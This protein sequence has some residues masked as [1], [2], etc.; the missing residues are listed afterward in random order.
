MNVI[1]G[2]TATLRFLISRRS[3]R[4]QRRVGTTREQWRT[5]L[6][7]QAVAKVL[8]VGPWSL[9]ICAIPANRPSGAAAEPS[10]TAKSGRQDE[11]EEEARHY[12]SFRPTQPG[13]RTTCLGFAPVCSPL[14]STCV[15]FTKTSTTP[16]AY[17]CGGEPSP[18]IQSRAA[19]YSTAL[20]YPSSPYRLSSLITQG[21]QPSFSVMAM[22]R[23]RASTG[24]A[25]LS[26]A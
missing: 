6:V 14:R 20:A 11:R 18:A 7:S 15:P 16:T 23:C 9:R 17:W 26:R 1:A 19:A 12:F 21:C 24:A 4:P 3:L 22:R 25:K 13:P 5:R 10:D 8:H 2:A